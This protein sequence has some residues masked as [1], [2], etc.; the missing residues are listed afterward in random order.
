MHEAARTE[1]R[2]CTF[3]GL[4][5][6]PLYVARQQSFFAKQ[7]LDVEIVYTTGSVPQFT[8]LVHGAYHLV[9]TAPDNVINADDNPTAF[10]LDPATFPRIVMLFGGSTGAL[11]LFAQPAITKFVDLRG[12]V[13]GVDNP[14]SGFALVLRDILARNGLDLE[15]DYT[16]A[17]AGGTS[18]RLTALM[19]GTVIGTILYA[20]FDTLAAEKGFCKLASSTDYYTAYASLSTAA[21]QTWVDTHADLVIRY[22]T[23]LKHALRWIYDPTHAAATQAIMEKESALGLDATLAVKAYTAFVHPTT[24][25]GEDGTLNEAGLQQVIDLRATYGSPSGPQGVP[26]NYLDPRWYR[27]AQI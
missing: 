24:G 23:A 5:N 12:A 10:G 26:A 20:P 18:A 17:V 25:F 6:L 9:Q 11:S 19:S 14:A 16:F 3:R 2:V 13:L 4:Q 7:A 15:R 1:L 8:G 27:Q 21:T 22:I